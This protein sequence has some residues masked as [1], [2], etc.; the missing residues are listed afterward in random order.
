MLIQLRGKYPNDYDK[1][2][3]MSIIHNDKVYMAWLAIHACF[4]VNGVAELHTELLKTAELK[5]WY[6]LYPEKFNNKTN[7]ITQRRWLLNA[8]PLLAEFITK[9]IGN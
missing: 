5:E 1:H 6:D 8:N 7:G 3:R 4:S 9:R 2:Q